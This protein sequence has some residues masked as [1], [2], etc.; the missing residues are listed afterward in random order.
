MALRY[1]QTFTVIPKR[2]DEEVFP[3][4][5]L[6]YDGCFFDKEADATKVGTSGCP[7]T[8]SLRVTGSVSLR[9]YVESK[10]DMPTEARWTSFGWV[11]LGGVVTRRI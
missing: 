11:L 2:G 1:V 3:L 9:R 10:D 5:M 8:G 7:A 4:D 6:R